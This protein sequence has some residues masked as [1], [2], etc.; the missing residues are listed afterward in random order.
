MPRQIALFRAFLR[1]LAHLPPQ[2]HLQTSG[3]YHVWADAECLFGDQRLNECIELTTMQILQ[4]WPRWLLWACEQRARATRDTEGSIAQP[5]PQ[6][7]PILAIGS[8]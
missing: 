6:M 5:T 3:H 4:D 2:T 8:V 7:L 1:C